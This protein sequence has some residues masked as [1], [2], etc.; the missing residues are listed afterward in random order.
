MQARH[1]GGTFS[2]PAL[3]VSQQGRL[4][5][6]TIIF[7]EFAKL[8][9][10][11]PVTYASMI[12]NAWWAVGGPLVGSLAARMAAVCSNEAFNHNYYQRHND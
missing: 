11:V 7:Y 12:D 8:L 5:I 10:C 2:G 1:V 6:I 3:A 4:R 9:F